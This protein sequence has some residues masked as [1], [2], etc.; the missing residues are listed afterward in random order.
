MRTATIAATLCLA[1]AASGS[2]RADESTEQAARLFRAGTESY[3]H[4]AFREAARQFESAYR[5]APRGA[6]IYDAGLAW[7]QA[8]ETARA[9]DDFATAI[10]NGDTSS[11]QRSDATARL[12]ALE[13]R[14]ARLVVTG[15]ADA[16]VTV[17][18]GAESSLPLGVH[19]APGT[20]ALFVTY[21]GGRTESRD[22]DAR[23]GAEVV[24]RLAG[25]GSGQDPEVPA[26][27]ETPPPRSEESGTSTRRTIAW[28]SLVGAGVTALTGVYFYAQGDNALNR[29]EDGGSIDKGL[30][31]QAITDRTVTQVL[32]GVTGALVATSVVLFLTSSGSPSPTSLRL[33]P[34]GACLRVTF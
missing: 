1:T 6:A 32:A 21:A 10:G 8:G 27:R 31:D 22:I 34:T 20:H 15:P 14:L 2:A 18:D 4:H 7:E 28:I 11:Q 26:P 9:A 19:L 33:G 17:D 30:H 29:F 24:V 13:A 16:H 23:A 5:I 12:K 25:V 3:A